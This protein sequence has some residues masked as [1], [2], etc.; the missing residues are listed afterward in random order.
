VLHIYTVLQQLRQGFPVLLHDDLQGLQLR[1][2][3]QLATH[4]NW[5]PLLKQVKQPLQVVLVQQGNQV[6]LAVHVSSRR[7]SQ[8]AEDLMTEH[9]CGFMKISQSARVKSYMQREH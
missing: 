9:A 5:I 7:I 2:G 1:H 8:T 6:L 4:Q 3:A